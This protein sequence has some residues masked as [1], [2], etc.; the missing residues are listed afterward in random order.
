MCVLR[1]GHP[2]GHGG[3]DTQAPELHAFRPKYDPEWVLPPSIARL[4]LG[5]SEEPHRDS[6]PHKC[7]WVLQPWLLVEA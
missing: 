5:F 7:C 2:D 4:L 1:R 6:R 3:S